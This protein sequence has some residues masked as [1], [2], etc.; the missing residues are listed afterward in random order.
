MKN[1]QVK[2]LAVV[3]ILGISFTSSA[4]SF[5]GVRSIRART[6]DDLNITVWLTEPPAKFGKDV[7]VYF[8][9]EN[10]SAKT[11]YLVSKDQLEID[12]AGDEFKINP[13]TIG[14]DEHGG[15]DYSF[16]QIRKG[17]VHHGKFVIPAQ[18]ISRD[19]VWFIEVG[20]TFVDDIKGLNRRLRP[21]D[22]PV[23][24]RG[25][26]SQRANPVSLGKLYLEMK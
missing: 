21:G 23:S 16:I 18:K 5:A 24:F 22:D 7:S 10:L 9:I 26:L 6:A 13:F 25:L 11:V 2:L 15:T 17:A 8:K 3:L 1:I 12:V 19:G 20:L 14:P 4:G